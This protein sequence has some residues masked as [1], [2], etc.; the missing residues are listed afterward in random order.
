MKRLNLVLATTSLLKLSG[1]A[2]ELA[3]GYRFD[4]DL[5]F[6]SMPVSLAEK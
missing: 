4:S 6:P 5:L 3:I 2:S 1:R